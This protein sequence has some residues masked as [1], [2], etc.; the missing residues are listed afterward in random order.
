M[1]DSGDLHSLAKSN[2]KEERLFVSVDLSVFLLPASCFV[3][4]LMTLNLVIGCISSFSCNQRLPSLLY[5]GCFRGHDRILTIALVLLAFIILLVVIGA[6]KQLRSSSTALIMSC[7][8]YCGF[9]SAGCLPLIALTD[10]VNSRH[11]IPLEAFNSTFSICFILASSAWVLMF[12]LKF[13]GS[14]LLG[15]AMAHTALKKWLVLICVCAGMTYFEAHFGDRFKLHNY[16]Y[17]GLFSWVLLVLL[18][19]LPGMIGRSLTQLHLNVSNSTENKR[20]V[21]LQ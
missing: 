6:E 3:A 13:K 9:V 20:K 14:V 10:D 5:L 7:M 16:I 21:S 17:R 19:V 15:N 18:V 4:A 1:E 8:R 12:V 2:S 11:F